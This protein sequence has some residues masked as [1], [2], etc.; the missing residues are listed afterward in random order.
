M[1]VAHPTRTCQ[2]PSEGKLFVRF[3][4]DVTSC[5]TAAVVP[6]HRSITLD[7]QA[8]THRIAELAVERKALD[9]ITLDISG[10]SSYADALVIASGTSDRHVQSIAEMIESTLNKEGVRSIGREGLREGQWALIDFGG[11]VLHVF[12]QFTRESFDL[13]SLWKTAPKRLAQGSE[14]SDPNQRPSPPATQFGETSAEYPI[15]AL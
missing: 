11:V 2:T 4:R 15:D 10:R 5:M 3:H 7:T 9:V 1:A 8:L 13:E 12:H 6:C 14:R